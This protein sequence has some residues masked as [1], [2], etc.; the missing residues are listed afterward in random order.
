MSAGKIALGIVIGASLIF[1]IAV[2]VGWYFIFG[3]GDIP[4]IPFLSAVDSDAS[5][6]EDPATIANETSL[7][8]DLIDSQNMQ[9]APRT[10]H[11]SMC[12]V[13]G[14]TIPFLDHE[15][16][17]T[18]LHM[19]MWGVDGT[20]A[21]ALDAAYQQSYALAGY[22]IYQDR[23]A[24]GV[25]WESYQTVYQNGNC[26]RHVI[27]AD[28]PAVLANYGHEVIVGTGHGTAMDYVSYANFVSRY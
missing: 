18:N 7:D 4:L 25:G 5:S 9:Y 8:E 24:A 16:H 1:A 28:G 23:Y 6:S 17:I 10:I 19:T 14:R 22:T 13:L 15:P 11:E 26:G 20:T 12:F 3:P 2:G 27:I 21:V